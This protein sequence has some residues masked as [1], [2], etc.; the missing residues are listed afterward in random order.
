MLSEALLWPRVED[1]V[2]GVTAESITGMITWQ[3]LCPKKFPADFRVN[4]HRGRDYEDVLIKTSSG[5]EEFDPP[6]SSH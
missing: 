2:R 1:E 6:D 4:R 5:A 3:W